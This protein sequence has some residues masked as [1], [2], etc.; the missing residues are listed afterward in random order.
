[1]GE[2]AEM[3]PAEIQIAEQVA[4]QVYEAVVGDDE[5]PI[6]QLEQ[7]SAHT[8]IPIETIVLWLSQRVLALSKLARDF[9]ASHVMPDL[10]GEA[11][12]AMHDE[13]MARAREA[14]ALYGKP[15]KAVRVRVD[16]GDF[17]RVSGMVLCEV[18]QVE[19][20]DHDPV[21]GFPWL[22]H[23]CDGRLLKP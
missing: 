4:M 1:M 11:Q 21:I 2:P 13:A 19:Y 9:S 17:Q 3:S 5:S 10:V 12:Q 20:S 7:C 16:R 15:S 6:R 14:R 23:G 22:R 18:C 8:G